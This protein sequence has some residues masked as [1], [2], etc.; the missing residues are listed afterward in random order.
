M[1]R[2]IKTHIVWIVEADC[3]FALIRAGLVQLIVGRA[4]PPIFQHVLVR[5]NDVLLEFC[6]RAVAF[7]FTLVEL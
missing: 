7:V 3:G 2:N 4:R 5:C 1:E 6:G